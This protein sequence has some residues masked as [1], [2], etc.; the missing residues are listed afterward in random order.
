MAR[1]RRRNPRFECKGPA[2]VKL[3]PE[4]GP[5]PAS[6]VNLSVEGCLIEFKKPHRLKQDTTVELTFKIND[7]Q[8]LVWGQVRAIRSDTSVGFQFP[9][10]NERVRRRIAQ[11]IEQLIE[12]FLLKGSLPSGVSENRRYPRVGCIGT[13]G[14]QLAAGEPIHPAKIVNL[15]A[16]GCLIVLQDP[17]P[18]EQ[19]MMVELT[20]QINHLP[21][22]VRGQVKA[23]RSETRIGFEFPTL[24][25]RVR[26]QI[27]DMVDELID[28]VVKRFAENKELV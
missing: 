16:G 7:Q 20:F 6:I 18:L 12:D 8:F 4:E 28:N 2:S 9:L 17:Q 5:W 26:R 10:L 15:S 14:I 13:A 22:R 3:A 21:F 27:E 24:S 23:I 19:D 11:M 1:E 25:N